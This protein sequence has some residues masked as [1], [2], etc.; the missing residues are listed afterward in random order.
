MIVCIDTN[1][2]L[3]MFGRSAP[4]LRI[5][6]ALLSGR[7]TWAV[8]TEILLEYEEVAA[9]EMGVAE[10]SKLMRFIQI[11]DHSRG[12]SFFLTDLPLSNNSC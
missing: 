8:S 11:A 4:Y 1:A 9:R 7:F 3:G 6:H 10:A 5:R 2:V 12:R